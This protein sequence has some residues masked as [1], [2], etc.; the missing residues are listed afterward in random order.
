M[1]YLYLLRTLRAV[2]VLEID[3]NH[4]ISWMRAKE[5]HIITSWLSLEQWLLKWM[6]I[7]D[8]TT[9][10]TV[11]NFHAWLSTQ[12]PGTVFIISS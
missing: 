2:A 9:L 7:I 12:T 3:A 4:I 6:L 10:L 11:L 5:I 8:I 1:S